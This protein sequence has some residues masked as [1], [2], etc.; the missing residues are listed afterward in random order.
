MIK[1][2]TMLMF[3]AGFVLLTACNKDDDERPT[4][5]HPVREEVM[6]DN[7]GLP[8][9]PSTRATPEQTL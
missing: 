2:I 3:L 8:S 5:T 6:P 1:K 4:P 7:G 9:G